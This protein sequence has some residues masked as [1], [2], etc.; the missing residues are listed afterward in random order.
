MHKH[1]KQ[2][3][4]FEKR[5]RTSV[6]KFYTGERVVIRGKDLHIDFQ[7]ADWMKLLVFSITGREFTDNQISLLSSIWV[8]S[9]YPDPR[10]WNN[11]V[12]SLTASA[13]SI[14][15]LAIAAATA[16]SDA[17]I[18]GGQTEL[19]AMTFLIKAKY[20]LDKGRPLEDL[21][22]AELKT[23]RNIG[24]FGRPMVKQDERIPHI[25]KRAKDLQLDNGIY[26]QIL[27]DVQGILKNRK[28]RIAMNY[29]GVVSALCADMGMSPLEHHA[30]LI[31]V[32]SA[33]MLP[34]YLDALS[35]HSEGAFFPLRCN[36]IAYTGPSI[37]QWVV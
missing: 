14:C 32:F 21:V 18:Y 19:R 3:E 30:Y 15:S 34:C 2:L 13:R 22:F 37:R 9:S 4:E 8:Y 24:G 17:H 29:G 11:R 1:V 25:F 31:L 35:G 27:K 33:G 5:W 7:D 28:Y 20:Q 26:L 10:I 16:V 23:K 6:G 36:S 12:A